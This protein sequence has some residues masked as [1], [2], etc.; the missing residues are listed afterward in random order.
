[1]F[2]SEFMSV[3]NSCSAVELSLVVQ[4]YLSLYYIWWNLHNM[5]GSGKN[6][7]KKISSVVLRAVQWASALD[8]TQTASSELN[9]Y[10]DLT[11]SVKKDLWNKYSMKEFLYT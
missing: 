7:Y 3:E 2:Y 9:M 8:V 11:W 10:E 6:M 5:Q 4:S 1:M